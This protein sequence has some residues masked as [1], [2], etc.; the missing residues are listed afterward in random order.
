MG[1]RQARLSAAAQRCGSCPSP[2]S[3]LRTPR[4]RHSDQPTP[5]PTACLHVLH[6]RLRAVLQQALDALALLLGRLLK[7]HLGGTG[8]RRRAG[9]V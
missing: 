5:N 3:R 2:V 7:L 6:I 1:V 8:G 4:T 9:G